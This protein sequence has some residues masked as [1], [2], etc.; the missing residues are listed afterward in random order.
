VPLRALVMVAGI[1]WKAEEGFAGEELT[2]LDQHQVRTWT[3]WMRWA[4]LAMLAHAFLSVMTAARPRPAVGD[5]HRDE[6]GHELI[7]VTRN[8]IRRLYPGL[9]PRPR[10]ARDQLRWSSWRRRHQATA[11]NCHYQRR[12]ALAVTL[13]TK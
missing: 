9:L 8:E 3:S 1:R 10:P 4:I 13:I 12:Q 5:V 11:R 7:P 2:A 6:A